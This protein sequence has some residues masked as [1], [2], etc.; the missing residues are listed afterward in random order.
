MADEDSHLTDS[1][2]SQVKFCYKSNINIDALY[3][4]N[5]V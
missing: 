3:S 1:R 4:N 5:F 2:V